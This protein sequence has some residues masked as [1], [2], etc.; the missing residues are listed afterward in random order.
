MTFESVHPRLRGELENLRNF[1]ERIRGSSPLA[2]GTPTPRYVYLDGLWFIPA[3]A[4][5]SGAASTAFM[6]RPVH[7]RLRG[8][9]LYPMPY[10]ISSNGS[11][12]LARGTPLQVFCY[13]QRYRFIPACAG[14]SLKHGIKPSI[15]TLAFNRSF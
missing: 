11:S 1:R 4:G 9:L 12:P 15:R 2:R 13:Y 14:N 8:E 3:C 5:N 7:P 6:L 10:R